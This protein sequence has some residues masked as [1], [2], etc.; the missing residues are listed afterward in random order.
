MQDDHRTARPSR[1]GISRLLA[2]SVAITMWAVG[3]GMWTSSGAASTPSTG[4][5]GPVSIG[6]LVAQSHKESGLTIYGNAPA[7]YFKP[8][9]TAFE[10]QYPWIN[11]QDYDLTDNQVFSKYESEHAQGA[12]SADLLISSGPG[13]WVQAE[14]NHLIQNVTPQGL[15]NFPSSTNQGHG[16]YVMSPE[17][18]L[19]AYNEKLLTA[20]DVPA[21]YAQLVRDVSANPAKYKLVSYPIT[22]PLAYGAVYGLIHILGAKTVWSDLK[23]MGPNTKTYNEG[24][25][26]LQ[27]MVQGGASV[28]YIS[29]GLSQGVL[30]HFKGLANYVFMADATPLIPRGIGVAAGA[31]SPASAQL[32]MDYLFSG[33]GQQAL[34]AAGFEASEN[35]FTATNGCTANLTDLYKAVPKSRVY[36]VPY[37][38]DLLRQQAS[39]TA[40]WNRAFH[41]GS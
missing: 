41:V 39:I 13:L 18:I 17:P 36:L 20:K 5:S 14:Q 8:V 33:P 35:G 38:S 25:D 26:G 23:V 10:Q 24:L 9:I 12:R 15:A 3:A 32:F 31:A 29:S 34:C 16:V 19:S 11:V 37:S 28:G 4:R 30:P 7:P 1:H 27:Y 40:R 21:T 22:N 2:L 6:K